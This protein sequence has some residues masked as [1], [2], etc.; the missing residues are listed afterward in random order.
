MAIEQNGK[1]YGFQ[2]DGVIGVRVSESVR[3]D[4]VI[5]RVRSWTFTSI[6]ELAT[7]ALQAEK[8]DED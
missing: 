7:W 2:S 5:M 3:E 4:G 1:I 6:E 8:V